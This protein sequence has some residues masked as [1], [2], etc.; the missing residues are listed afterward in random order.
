MTPNVSTV[1]W[2][3]LPSLNRRSDELVFGLIPHGLESRGARGKRDISFVDPTLLAFRILSDIDHTQTVGP[4]SI[5]RSHRQIRD[6]DWPSGRANAGVSIANI[7][8]AQLW[9]EPVKKRGVCGLRR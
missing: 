6:E 9:L 7:A 8:C 4:E 5:R 2:L 1:S 3:T